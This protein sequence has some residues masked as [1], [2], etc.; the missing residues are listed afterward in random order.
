MKNR[1]REFIKKNIHNLV[2]N[3]FENIKPNLI[4]I[5]LMYLVIL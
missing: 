3:L 1:I 4:K 5:G 2:R